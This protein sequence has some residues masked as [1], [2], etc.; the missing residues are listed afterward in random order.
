M[1]KL[2]FYLLWFDEGTNKGEDGVSSHGD[3]GEVGHH[4]CKPV[5]GID[6]EHVPVLGVP[7]APLHQHL[8]SWWMK[9]E[10]QKYADFKHI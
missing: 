6:V 7:F 8:Q 4:R 3:V 5:P 2:V 10:Y 9:S 1:M